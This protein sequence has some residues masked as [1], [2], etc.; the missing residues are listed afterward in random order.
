VL[1]ALAEPESGAMFD[2]RIEGTD[3]PWTARLTA[4]AVRDFHKTR[5]EVL[6]RVTL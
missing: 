6:A 2:V 5:T 4:S 3:P 1:A